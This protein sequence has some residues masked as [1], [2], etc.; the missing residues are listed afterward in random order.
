MVAVPNA[1][2]FTV[3][4]NVANPQNITNLTANLAMTY[5]NMGELSRQLFAPDGEH[6]TLFQYQLPPGTGPGITTQGL[7]SGNALGVFGFAPPTA[8]GIDIGTVF[9]DN[10]TRNIFDPTLTGTNGVTPG[11][12]IGH[13]RP[14]AAPGDTTSSMIAFVKSVATNDP[15]AFNNGSWR[16]IITANRPEQT[17]GNLRQFSLTFTTGMTRD[18]SAHNLASFFGTPDPTVPGVAYPTVPVHGALGDTFTSF[19]APSSPHRA[20]LG[21]GHG[22]R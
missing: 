14:E 1:T 9:D 7:P 6:I 4:V 17:A 12:Y 15:A 20:R 3:N 21:L 5:A 13:F 11:N 8:F 10:A 22:Y 16:L 18:S 2:T 19:T